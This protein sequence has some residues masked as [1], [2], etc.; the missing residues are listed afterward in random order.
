MIIK[1]KIKPYGT[2]NIWC[3][4][5][6]VKVKNKQ[7]TTTTQSTSYPSHFKDS[8]LKNKSKNTSEANFHYKMLN[9]CGATASPK[10]VL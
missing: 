5:D 7:A 2:G 1:K 3:Y 6:A 4:N 10:D 8:T 9:L